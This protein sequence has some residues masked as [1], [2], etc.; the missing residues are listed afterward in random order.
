VQDRNSCTTRKLLER[1]ILTMPYLTN[2]EAIRAE[3][4]VLIALPLKMKD[5][6]ASPVRAIAVEA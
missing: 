3:R 1:D 6:E 5:V 2:L 4:F